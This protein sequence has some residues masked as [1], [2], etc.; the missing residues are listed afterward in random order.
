[1]NMN[2]PSPPP[3]TT[4]FLRPD[5]R[6][7]LMRS[8]RKMEH[9][10]G[11]TPLFIDT[12][13]PITPTFPGPH[14]RRR[15]AY[16]YV[17]PA[18]SSSLGVYPPPDEDE[19]ETY[20]S[21]SQVPAR[22]LLAVRVRT[23]NETVDPPAALS[24]LVPVFTPPK[25][26]A[27]K[28]HRLRTRKMARIV[29][30]LG[31]NVPTELVFPEDS[32]SKPRHTSSTRFIRP[33]RRGSP[34]LTNDESESGE[35]ESLDSDAESTSVYSTTS[36]GDTF[37]AA[38]PLAMPANPP[39]NRRAY[40]PSDA[41]APVPSAPRAYPAPSRAPAPSE[42]RPRAHPSSSPRGPAPSQYSPS[43]AGS[44]SPLVNNKPSPFAP[45][46]DALAQP[47]V[48]PSPVAFGS[49][50]DSAPPASFKP[51]RSEALGYDRGTHRT[52]KGW[53]GEWVATDSS[54]VQ[55]MDEVA[56][57]LRGLRLR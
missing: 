7:R 53:S 49:V 12:S 21:T 23:P 56:N 52:E 47:A 11:E 43:Q 41:R 46:T 51:P 6:V 37:V 15:S 25:S 34:P 44:P 20:A 16:I 39:S 48:P 3:V 18:R 22:P 38:Q 14:P 45:R 32:Y 57:R 50:F 4:H 19:E 5:Q 55:S 13:S 36:G 1:M 8:T 28:L 54:G 2:G 35:L 24:P 30:T 40:A 26:P 29:R 31:E 27:D 42:P 10:L 17:A 33:G 9:L